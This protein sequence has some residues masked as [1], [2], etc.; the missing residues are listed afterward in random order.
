LSPSPQTATE[1][2]YCGALKAAE[3]CP[4]GSAAE[5]GAAEMMVRGLLVGL[6]RDEAEVGCCGGEIADAGLRG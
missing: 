6:D 2:Y 3:S 1:H 5:L 4:C